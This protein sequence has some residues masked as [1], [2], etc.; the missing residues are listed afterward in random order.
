MI[1]LL[2][3]C[4]DFLLVQIIYLVVYRIY[5]HPLSKFP[6]PKLASISDLW[7]VW[8]SIKGQSHLKAYEVHQ[9]YGSNP[10]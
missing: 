2:H 7:T 5:F 1:V 8:Y 6:G 9:K 10:W 3:S 4:A